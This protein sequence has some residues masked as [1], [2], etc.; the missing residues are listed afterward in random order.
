M[1]AIAWTFAGGMLLFKG[2]L[3]LS[4]I[5]TFLGVKI[6][7]SIVG[8]LL[9]YFLL[10]SKISLKHI[11]RINKITIDKPCLFSF[12]NIKSYILMAIMI[13]S[14]ILLRKFGIIPSEYFVMVYI[15]MGIPLFLSSFRFYFNGIYYDKFINSVRKKTT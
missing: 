1:A 9:F 4:N 10:F 8:G 12:F 7:I 13:T 6:S 5:K 3:L 15:T 2:I 11:T 14:G